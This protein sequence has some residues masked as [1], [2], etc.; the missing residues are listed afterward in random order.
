MRVGLAVARHGI[1]V[2]GAQ[3]RA[4]AAVDSGRRRPGHRR[5]V[6]L[7][8]C[9]AGVG[10]PAARRRVG[11]ARGGAGADLR[12]LVHSA[13]GSTGAAARA[14]PRDECIACNLGGGSRGRWIRRGFKR[15]RCS[16]GL[17]LDCGG[18][19][20]RLLRVGSRPG[21]VREGEQRVPVVEGCS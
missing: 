21:P 1:D 17:G 9:S 11:T 2:A 15:A 16:R 10:L 6:G 20:A 3:R 5:L 4:E 14:A 13:D 18:P 12:R 19:R 8:G 7:R